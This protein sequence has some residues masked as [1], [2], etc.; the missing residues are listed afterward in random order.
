MIEYDSFVNTMLTAINRYMMVDRGQKLL[1]GVSGGPDSVALLHALW[2]VSGELDISLHVAHLNH[3]FRG[4]DSDDDAEYVRSLATDLGLDYTI[5]K[6]DVPQIKISL[7]VSDEEAARLVRHDFLDRTAKKAGAHHIALGHTADDQVETVLIN[8]LRGT[9][10]DGLSGMPPV[11]D[12]I[13]RPLIE[14]KRRSVEEYI[15]RHSLHPRTD[16]TNL[17]PEYTRNRIR[18]ELLPELRQQYNNDIDG[19]ILRLTELVRVDS[20]Y[21]NMEADK[22]LMH[23]TIDAGADTLKLDAYIL[24]SYPL[25]IKRRVIRAAIKKLR[26]E[27]IDIG[28]IHINDIISLINGGS[29]FRYELPGG[30]YID[31]S[32]KFLTFMVTRPVDTQVIYCYTLNVPGETFVPEIQS[33]VKTELSTGQI[34]DIRTS[35]D[36]GIVLDYGCIRGELKIRNWIH[37]DRMNPMG[38][39]GSKKIQD[40]FSDKKIPKSERYRIPIIVDNEKIIWVA[41]LSISENVKVTSDTCEYLRIIIL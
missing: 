27:L 29:N 37:G 33:T 20:A 30:T 28:Y 32:Y 9:G 5:E 39:G 24:N 18:L 23:V 31:R 36:N 15:E 8:F 22:A 40:I 14:L 16:L 12:K 3:S 41:G 1:V 11:R 10:I 13:I 2:S 25:A 38:L 26:G 7:R 17:Q 4:Q 35:G 6:I 34:D 19:I 21:I